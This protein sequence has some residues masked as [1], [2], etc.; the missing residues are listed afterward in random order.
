MELWIGGP[1]ASEPKVLLVR[2]DMPLERME[3]QRLSLDDSCARK[4][5][6]EG[7]MRV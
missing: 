5:W 3:S 6:R 4:A 1:F 2:K 7:M